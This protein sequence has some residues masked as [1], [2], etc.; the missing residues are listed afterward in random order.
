MTKYIHD[1]YHIGRKY[2]NN[3]GI[4]MKIEN[5]EIVSILGRAEPMVFASWKT[6]QGK[7]LKHKFS[8]GEFMRMFES[9][10]L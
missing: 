2:T 9:S 1:S 4:T 3:K 7:A 10:K 6:K 8:I 5:M